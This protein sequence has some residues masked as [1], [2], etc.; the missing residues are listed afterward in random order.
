M[1]RTFT[2]Y[3]TTTT[4]AQLVKKFEKYSSYSRII[5]NNRIEKYKYK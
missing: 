3:F 2:T 5:V 1:E 4:L